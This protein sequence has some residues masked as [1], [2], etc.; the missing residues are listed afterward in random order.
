M[1]SRFYNPP[2]KGSANANDNVNDNNSVHKTGGVLFGASNENVAGNESTDNNDTMTRTPS[3]ASRGVRSA[4]NVLRSSSRLGSGTGFLGGISGFATGMANDANSE[5]L[6]LREQERRYHKVVEENF[7]LKLQLDELQR[8]VDPDAKWNADRLNS[9]NQRLAGKVEELQAMLDSRSEQFMETETDSELSRLRQEMY[10]VQMQLQ[11][12]E[13]EVERVNMQLAQQAQ[14][15]S[16]ASSQLETG[17]QQFVQTSEERDMLRNRIQE[18]EAQF[19]NAHEQYE[20]L[21]SERDALKAENEQN[22]LQHQNVVRELE[23]QI[24]QLRSQSS[25]DAELN[26]RVHELMQENHSL[27]RKLQEA[28]TIY[29]AAISEKE[30]EQ[31]AAN[32][33][34]SEVET[35]KQQLSFLEQQNAE[36]QRA[37]DKHGQTQPLLRQ[38][39]EHNKQ[40]R[41][42]LSS[43]Q[44]DL[45][46][47]QRAN[48]EMTHE[49]H[50][51]RVS[52]RTALEE[53]NTVEAQLHELRRQESNFQNMES[54]RIEELERKNNELK[55]KLETARIAQDRTNTMLASSESNLGQLN[56]DISRYRSQIDALQQQIRSGA[57]ERQE[58]EQLR[59]MTQAQQSQIQSL[60]AQ[61]NA[62]QTE[63]EKLFREKGSL[64]RAQERARQVQMNEHL[65][66]KQKLQ[67]TQ[68]EANSLKRDVQSKQNELGSLRQELMAKNQQVSEM[69]LEQMKRNH[70][71]LLV[72]SRISERDRQINSLKEQRDR[73]QTQLESAQNQLRSKTLATEQEPQ[74]STQDIRQITELRIEKDNL[75]RVVSDL[76]T[77]VRDLE[78]DL[79]TTEDMCDQA[80]VAREQALAD[81]ER[82]RTMTAA[83]NRS[84]NA[85]KNV[86]AQ[87]S[88]ELDV[89][90][91]KYSKA[92]EARVELQAELDEVKSKLRHTERDNTNLRG[93]IQN[94]E[95]QLK[96]HTQRIY[97]LEQIPQQVAES[98][99]M[100]APTNTEIES[101]LSYTMSNLKLRAERE[102]ASLRQEQKESAQLR[103][104]LASKTQLL[105]R[106]TERAKKYK[107]II[108]KLQLSLNENTQQMQMQTPSK[109]KRSSGGKKRSDNEL[110]STEKFKLALQVAKQYQRDGM[111]AQQD[112]AFLKQYLVFQVDCF[113]T[114]NYMGLEVFKR[115]GVVPEFEGSEG[116]D[117]SDW[118]P[119]TRPK[120]KTVV[121][122]VIA[123]LRIQKL[124]EQ[125]VKRKTL[126]K[127][128]L[129]WKND[130]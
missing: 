93:D 96:K 55:S 26:T 6:P 95:M 42:E 64:E 101:N 69:K 92:V 72:E 120:L 82:L 34:K 84:D 24:G 12:K 22:V 38:H 106:M 31:V 61:L 86:P 50:E 99:R 112:L 80:T 68:Q 117:S 100:G 126:F 46:Q 94:L 108:G 11:S 2:G 65:Q 49:L 17:R 52:E 41:D 66:F 109:L 21:Q 56:Q 9:E 78:D 7:N 15:A 28:E 60:Q 88:A 97:E 51:A 111:R 16:S 102:K 27:T 13:Q 104:D 130:Q 110:V 67:A 127:K 125:Q 118:S 70:E 79:A 5:N 58:L 81:L 57:P 85:T 45:H 121:V 129:N 114:F 98:A 44:Q 1:Q 29:K 32:R 19:R 18:L 40:L 105:D 59:S 25:N 23:E 4:R 116:D 10:N 63:G 14:Q 77:K 128:A 39:Q 83:N 107:D 75:A 47:L 62:Y 8:L 20:Y 43:A 76:E 89:L 74:R 71:K 87:L 90:T 3:L 30:T 37:V 48:D 115:T 53:L 33:A 36:L 54:Q 119:R 103:V 73:L 113:R 35:M 122:S 123:A 124:F 91:T